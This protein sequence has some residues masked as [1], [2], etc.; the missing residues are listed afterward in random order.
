MPQVVGQQRLAQ[1]RLLPRSQ[2][3]WQHQEQW[4]AAEVVEVD[5]LVVQMRVVGQLL[6]RLLRLRLLLLRHRGQR[7]TSIVRRGLLLLLEIKL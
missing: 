5:L 3:V 1:Q 2:Q 4:V 7:G 6:Q